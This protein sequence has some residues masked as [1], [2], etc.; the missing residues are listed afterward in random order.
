MNENEIRDMNEKIKNMLVKFIPL[1]EENKKLLFINRIK[2]FIGVYDLPGINLGSIK[3]NLIP[4][5]NCLY[6]EGCDKCIEINKNKTFEISYT[7]YGKEVIFGC[8]K[9]GFIECDDKYN[10]YTDRNKVLQIKIKKY[11]SYD[12][13]YIEIKKRINEKKIPEWFG[14]S[15]MFK[16]HEHNWTFEDFKIMISEI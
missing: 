16:I 15:V 14:L 1:I 4:F 3:I 8:Y 13:S 12:E 2:L 9:K 6:C 11:E 10:L 5:E 7:S